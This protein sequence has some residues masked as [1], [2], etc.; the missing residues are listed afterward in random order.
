[1]ELLWCTVLVFLKNE[2]YFIDSNIFFTYGCMGQS[3]QE[4]TKKNLWKT[5]FKKFEV[6]C[7]PQQSISLNFF[8]ILS[9]AILPGPFVNT[10]P[11]IFFTRQCQKFSKERYSLLK[12]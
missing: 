2:A 5:A 3:I 10:L 4:W 6:I 7:L 12:A 8:K 11:H 9:L 1:M